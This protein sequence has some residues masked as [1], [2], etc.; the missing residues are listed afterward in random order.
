MKI[1][2]SECLLESA[3]ACLRERE[4]DKERGC[5]C[6]CACLRERE[7]DKERGCVCVCVREVLREKGKVGE[8]VG[9]NE[10]VCACAS[11]FV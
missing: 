2:E 1:R 8:S 7:S 9:E 5:V 6:V 11:I 10:K 3:C 4:S